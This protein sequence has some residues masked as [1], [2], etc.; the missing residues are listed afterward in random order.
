MDPWL[1]AR[2]RVVFVLAT[3]ATFGVTR[4]LLR[5]GSSLEIVEAS[6]QEG[7]S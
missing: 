6:T 4:G 7:D 1:P 2:G 5:K 3:L